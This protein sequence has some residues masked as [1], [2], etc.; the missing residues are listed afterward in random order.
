[1]NTRN[2]THKFLRFSWGLFCIAMLAAFVLVFPFS[3][4]AWGSSPRNFEITHPFL[5]ERQSRDS[6]HYDRLLAER[7]RNKAGEDFK[8]LSPEEKA[9]MQRQ[10]EQWQSLPPEEK[11]L[12][13]KRMNKWKKM[14]PKEREL[15][16]HRFQQWQQIPP[17]ERK[18]LQQ[19]LEKWDQLSPQERDQ[20]RRR[21]GN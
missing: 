3:P 5:F 17:Q 10:Y 13:R 7:R 20:I 6:G 9:R 15:Y 16:Q 21:F 4:S 12:L 14:P 18:Q 1:M 2:L 8:D 11:D 19:D